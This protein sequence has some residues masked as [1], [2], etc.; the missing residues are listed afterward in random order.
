MVGGIREEIVCKYLQNIYSSQ[1]NSVSI[2]WENENCESHLPYD[3]LLIKKLLA[4]SL[5][6]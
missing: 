3:I 6:D 1:T 2:E 5:W 4:Q